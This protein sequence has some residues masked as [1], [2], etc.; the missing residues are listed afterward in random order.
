MNKHKAVS[1]QRLGKHVP[2]ETSTR[3]TI[4]EL[5]FRYGPRRGVIK[6][7]IG[8]IRLVEG[9]QL[10]WALQGRLR[11]EDAI[12]VLTV[13]IWQAFCTGSCDKRTWA[14]EAEES[15][16][17]EDIA[18]ERLLQPLQDEKD[19]ASVK[20]GDQQLRCNYL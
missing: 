11:R 14:R 1:E 13:D 15:P 6:K 9:W 12:A 2:A 17:L 18:T 10:I 8:A 20:C 3:A 7:T 16:L 4:E 19:F 5:C